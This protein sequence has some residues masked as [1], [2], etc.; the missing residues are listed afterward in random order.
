MAIET[1]LGWAIQ[2]PLDSE[3]NHKINSCPI[4]VMRV[5]VIEN[6]ADQVLEKFWKLEAI[7][8]EH[9][10]TKIG[11]LENQNIVEQFN[12]EIKLEN[13][14]YEVKFPWK[15]ERDLL[16]DNLSLA[17]KR[18]NSLVRRFMKDPLLFED[19]KKVIDEQLR[20]GVAEVVP[21]NSK[22]PI[23]TF[24]L[25]HQPV[26][27]PSATTSLR[28]VLDGSAHAK[29]KPSLNDCLSPGPNLNKEILLLL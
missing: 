17:T 11:Y 15:V 21:I 6:R 26:R 16:P 27:R 3:N 2:G 7:G 14:R 5:G 13:G 22:A 10:E 12:S 1:K 19:Y 18:G 25:P 29:G 9:E 24:Y 28:V 4:T 20:N 23:G 8:I